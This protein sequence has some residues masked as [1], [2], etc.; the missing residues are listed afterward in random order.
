VRA[1]LGYER[2]NLWG[3]SYGTRAALAYARQFPDRV[4]RVV[5]DGAAP[6]ELKLPLYVGRDAQRALERIYSECAAD[7]AC[8]KAFPQGAGALRALLSRLQAGPLPVTVTHPH[9]GERVTLDMHREGFVSAL[10]SLLYVPELTALL[11]LLIERAAAGDWG[12]F[13]TASLTLAEGMG[14][15]R[16]PLGMFLAVVCAEDVPQINAQ[17]ATALNQNTFFGSGWLDATIE[18]CKFWPHANL[19]PEYFEPNLGPEP[20]LVLSGEIDPVLP[21][22]WGELVAKRLPNARHLVVKGLAHG[23]SSVGCVP[24]LIAEFIE[25][26]ELSALDASCIERIARPAFFA[27]VGGT[28]P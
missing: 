4:R 18:T 23:V 20:T 16:I 25:G 26:T 27:R 19:G 8:S 5:L 22:E 12:P 21:P 10:R 15:D 6:T 24:D 13:I 14:E 17:E 3:G 7:P 11:P 28:E 9:T 1:A 2:I